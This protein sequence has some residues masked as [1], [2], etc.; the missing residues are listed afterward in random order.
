[1][2]TLTKI[3][4]VTAIAPYKL[5][6]EFSDGTHGT[7]DCASFIATGT[8]PMIMP[9]K[10]EAYFARVFLEMGAPTWPNGFDLAPWALQNELEEAERLKPAP[11]RGRDAAE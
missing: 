2:Q 4:K 3:R 6:L 10:D 7:Y 11:R 8:G 1:M 5:Q 9:L